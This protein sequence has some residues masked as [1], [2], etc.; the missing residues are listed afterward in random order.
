MYIE[1]NVSRLGQCILYSP[2]HLHMYGG[3]PFVSS[4]DDTVEFISDFVL[5]DSV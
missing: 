3:G 5:L 1:L 4:P 2:R